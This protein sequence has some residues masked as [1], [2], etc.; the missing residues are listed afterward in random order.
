MA[1]KYDIHVDM[2][3]V[4]RLYTY[5]NQE[6]YAYNHLV[7]TFGPQFGRDYKLFLDVNVQIIELF[8]IMCE[9]GI[10]IYDVKTEKLPDDLIEFVSIINSMSNKLKFLLSE[11]IPRS[12]ILS[13]VKKSMA[14]SILKFYV[15]QSEIRSRNEITQ[16]VGVEYKNIYNNL[17]KLTNIN[18]KH[19]QIDR[20]SCIIDFNR[21]ENFTLIT[22]PY[23]KYPIKIQ[24]VNLK[25]KK[26]NVL[27]LK[28]DYK[29]STNDGGWL[30]EIY[31][32][33][34]ET[35]MYKKIDRPTGSYVKF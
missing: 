25:N 30:L 29:V 31:N 34:P 20:K 4:N 6:L 33:P 17:P 5:M 32:L 35:Y 18:K 26:W 14:M 7:E 3:E 27:I 8:G 15:D 28:R 11:A 2:S 24:D 16:S 22:V 12:A 19:L 10:K 1:Y 23:S 9:K 21:L 13:S